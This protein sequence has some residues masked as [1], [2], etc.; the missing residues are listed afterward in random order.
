MVHL[1]QRVAFPVL[2]PSLIILTTYWLEY[3]V[4]TDEHHQEVCYGIQEIDLLPA[5]EVDYPE[6]TGDACS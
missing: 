6:L 3:P 2:G 5:I 1:R 4:G